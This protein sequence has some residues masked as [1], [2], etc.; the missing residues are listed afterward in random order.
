[1][2]NINNVPETRLA[3]LLGSPNVYEAGGAGSSRASCVIEAV[4]SQ[5]SRLSSDTKE[6][7]CNLVTCHSGTWITTSRAAF[8][9]HEWISL[10]LLEV[11]FLAW[12][13][14]ARLPDIMLALENCK[15][16]QRNL[17]DLLPT[18]LQE[19]LLETIDV[20]KAIIPSLAR[21]QQQRI[22]QHW[23]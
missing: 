23:Q 16:I 8:M 22:L 12:Y 9:H 21:E 10:H 1:M 7:I 2:A 18:G 19:Y 4:M 14:Y 3:Q 20:L 6:Q 11:D 13:A 5:T 15:D 17:Q